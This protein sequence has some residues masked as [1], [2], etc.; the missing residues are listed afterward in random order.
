MN[1]YSTP[2]ILRSTAKL[3]ETPALERIGY[4]TGVGVFNLQRKD[5][6]PWAAKIVSRNTGRDRKQFSNRLQLEAKVLSSLNHPNIIGYRAFVKRPDGRESLTDL[7]EMRKEENLGPYPVE[8]ITK[9]AVDIAKALEYLHSSL[10][11]HGDIKS[12]NILVKN[13]F[14]IVKLCDFGVSLPLK[15][16]GTLHKVKGCKALYIGT[17]CWSAPEVLKG[18]EYLGAIITSKA[19]IF[20]Y[21]LVLWEMMTLSFPNSST[22]INESY[23]TGISDDLDAHLG[24]TPPLPDSLVS[25]PRYKQIIELF[26]MCTIQDYKKRPSAKQILQFMGIY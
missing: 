9:V 21:G 24:E 22:T 17:P 10:V 1:N 12:G 26:N 6:S 3:P 23:Y 14:E 7:I 8:Y 5:Q 4:G 2:K 18:E 16:D 13:N 25:D 20:S 19:D 11:L 15:F